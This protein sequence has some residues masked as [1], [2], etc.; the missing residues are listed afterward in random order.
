MIPTFHFFKCDILRT[1]AEDHREKSVKTP[2]VNHVKSIERTRLS[3]DFSHGLR[4]I[5]WIF[6]GGRAGKRA[7]TQLPAWHTVSERTSEKRINKNETRQTI[8]RM[9]YRQTA[10]MEISSTSDIQQES[11]QEYER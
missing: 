8:A 3:N 1:G 7:S 5:K 4:P 2:S 10:G 9:Q 11:E 6:D